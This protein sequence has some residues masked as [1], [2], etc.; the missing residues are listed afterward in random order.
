VR[1]IAFAAFVGALVAVTVG[2]GAGN[3]SP[4]PLACQ[5]GAARAW[6][7][8]Q[9]DPAY[10][11]GTV[12][13]RFTNDQHYF[14]SRYN[15]RRSSAQIRRLDLGVYEIRFPGIKIHAVTAT[16]VSDEGVVTSAHVFEDTI[17]VSLRGPL[18]GNDVLVRRD[19]PFSI[20][21]Y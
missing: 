1:L 21:V 8:I 7:R 4:S 3:S 15:C 6:V 2:R 16:S 17:R 19:V 11:V 14:A 9:D 13:G 20:V 12:P 10:L 18:V 5:T